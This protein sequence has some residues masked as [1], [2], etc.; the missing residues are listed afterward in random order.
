[1]GDCGPCLCNETVGSGLWVPHANCWKSQTME[2]LRTFEYWSELVT[3]SQTEK[4]RND[5]K[6]LGLSLT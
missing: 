2:L 6:L 3:V 5:R 4:M 1:M